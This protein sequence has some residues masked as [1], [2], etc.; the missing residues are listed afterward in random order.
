M[1]PHTTL[2]RF[3]PPSSQAQ[4]RRIRRLL[5]RVRRPAV[6]GTLRRQ[7]AFSTYGY[8]R[9]T[10]VDRIFIE[11]FLTVHSADVAGEVLE[12]KD[13][14]YTMR[15]GGSRVTG[16]H[17]LDIDTGNH[18]ATIYGDLGEPAVLPDAA[19]DCVLLTQ[20]L[21]LIADLDTA[22]RSLH[23]TLRPGGV[24]LVTV[25]AVARVG[26]PQDGLFDGWRFT[27]QGLGHLLQRAFDPAVVVTG[28]GGNLPTTMAY[29]LGLAAEEMRDHELS[30]DDAAYPVTV[31]ARAVRKP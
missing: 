16:A 17:V 25:P 5:Q 20:T 7:T 22:V 1:E 27:P 4:L 30:V 2:K 6:W 10:P 8:Q 13:S 29:L 24:L 19:F 28:S 15:F 14:T 23:D 21:H 3:M 12:V 11:R 9:G 18:N 26:L 31:W